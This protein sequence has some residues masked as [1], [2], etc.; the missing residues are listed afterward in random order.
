MRRAAARRRLLFRQNMGGGAI[1]TPT[2]GPPLLTPLIYEWHNT[3]FHHTTDQHH[4]LKIGSHKD[5]WLRTEQEIHLPKLRL[6]FRCR[7][8][9]RKLKGNEIYFLKNSSKR[10]VNVR[11]CSF[12]S[13]F[14]LRAICGS[15]CKHLLLLSDFFYLI[16]DWNEKTY[17]NP[18]K[19]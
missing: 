12:R 17:S 7:V 10:S 8:V 18:Q 3:L 5:T 1:A 4:M 9:P 13:F 14:M 16:E 11:F 19:R 15:I 2:P 6:F